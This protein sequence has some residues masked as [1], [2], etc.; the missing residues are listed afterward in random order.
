MARQNTLISRGNR[1]TKPP[2]KARKSA[3]RGT[4]RKVSPGLRTD[5]RSKFVLYDLLGR[6]RAFYQVDRVEIEKSS[7]S[8]NKK[9]LTHSII[10]IDRSS[11]MRPHIEDLK[12]ML[13]KLLTL[14][15]YAQYDLLV[16]LISYSSLGDCTVHFQRRPIQEIMNPGSP[17]LKE[18]KRIH[19][20][21]RTCISQ[22]L[23]LAAELCRDRELTCVTLHSYGYPNDPNPIAELRKIDKLC[24]EMKKRPIFVNTIAYTD[25]AD[26]LLLSK[27]ANTVSGSCVQAGNIRQVYD[28]L[29]NSEKLLVSSLATPLE[30]PLG[31][32][33]DYQVFVSHLGGKINGAAGAL[34]IRG[35]KEDHD[36]II[37]KYKKLTKAGYK[38]LKD[39]PQVQA[40][41]AVLAFARSQL[42][43]GAINSSKY[44]LVSTFDATLIQRHC[45]A[46]TN[47][48]LAAMAQDLDTVLFQ[49]GILQEHEVRD[50][51]PVSTRIS[52]LALVHLLDQHKNEFAVNLDHLRAKYV[53]RGLRRIQGTRDESGNLIQPGLKAE[54]TDK[55]DYPP[56]SSFD[57]SHNTANL[58]MLI[59][60][61]VQ[62]I[63]RSG[64][65][66]IQ[67]VAGI[68]LDKLMSFNNYTLIGDGELNIPALKIRIGSRALFDILKKE[69]LLEND[70]RRD[71]GPTRRS[72]VKYNPKID[73]TL[74]L[75]TLPLVPPI[76]SAD[77]L[78]GVFED[79]ADMKAFDLDGVFEE[80]AGMKVLA[81]IIAA[82]LKGKTKKYT[83]E[84]IEELKRHYLSENLYLNFPTTTEYTDLHQA[85]AEGSVDTRVSYKIDIG[86]HRI[87]N[88]NKLMPANEFLDRH[89]EV[90]DKNGQKI[91]KPTFA[92]FLDGD[93]TV[94]WKQLSARTRI[95]AVD[96]FMR[97]IFDDFFALTNDG[98]VNGLLKRVGAMELAKALQE[99]HQGNNVSRTDYVTALSD[100][101][102]KLDAASEEIYQRK[103]SPLV[104]FIGSTGVLPDELDAKAQTA[105]Q[106]KAKYPDLALSKDEQEGMF[107]E[108]GET[109]LSVYAKIEY[110][111]Q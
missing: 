96:E 32:G 47:R 93:G 31:E 23:Q 76:G 71:A 101:R 110:F 74:R 107:F 45:R 15:E 59:A 42:S 66:P 43:E 12:D 33:Y 21:G 89:Y 81:S 56:V 5:V 58:N 35:L 86:N 80:L 62:L 4:P 68:Q 79:L 37:Y 111:S 9:T 16:T 55:S 98:I 46:L 102:H 39:V 30:V 92:I 99:K 27:V 8:L 19:A 22:A 11:S 40:S 36:A 1:I 104:F 6:E 17:E 18:I 10:L 75:D 28:A 41:E 105:K 52:V 87:L 70:D 29:C 95:T 49:P 3:P 82:Q 65:E 100:A 90:F 57:I 48:Q 72:A 109:I 78:D 53:P 51:V 38:K 2:A 63:P 84:Q 26:Y 91:N 44:A 88:L 103:V 67:H 14:D 106:L 64:G 34:K 69:K 85:L 97:P 77:D 83:P 61:P 13:I 94:R 20:T 60:R 108:I 25:S 50:R 7:K 54:F 24:E 73:Y